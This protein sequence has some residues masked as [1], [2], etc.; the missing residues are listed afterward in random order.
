MCVTKRRTQ[1]N[2]PERK[3]TQ[4]NANERKR[5]PANARKLSWCEWLGR[6][7][8]EPVGP[9][10]TA[11][12]SKA[13]PMT[14]YTLSFTTACVRIPAWACEK[15]ASDLGLGGGFR[16][17]LRFPPLLTTG[18]SQISHDWHK[19]DVKTKFKFKFWTCH[20]DSGRFR[21]TLH[22]CHSDTRA[23]TVTPKR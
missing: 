20:L 21:Y 18:Y 19:C 1:P 15:V 7:N 16:R 9:A 13:P 11:V 2:A 23:V 4:P 6:I 17:V 14:D 3:Q 5:T 10:L 8:F 12:W 22:G